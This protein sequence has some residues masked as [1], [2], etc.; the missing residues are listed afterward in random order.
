MVPD[1]ESAR[2]AFDDE[3]PVAATVRPLR[4]VALVGIDGSGK[5]TQAHELAH[6]LAARGLPAS[7]RRNAGGR[8]WF[9]RLATALGRRD[10]EHLLGRKAMLF[11]ESVLRW[12]A[13]LRTLLRRTVT[14]EIAI[15]DR[16][17]VCQ[18]ASIRAHAKTPRP[19]RLNRA[20]RRA[21]LA[22]RVFPRPD[23][24]FLLAVDPAVAHDRIERRGYDH[25]EMSYLRAATAA[26]EAL[27]EYGNFVVVDANG[28]PE[29][30]QQALLA[31]LR[32]WLPAPVP[33]P[34]PRVPAEPRRAGAVLLQARA[35]L[36][37]AVTLAAAASALTCQLV[38][39]F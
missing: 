27:P 36:L 28:T 18:Y 6:A 39:G 4:S 7:Y 31:H 2:P 35:L 37:T 15:M 26:Y 14:R 34:A 20:E 1:L 29:Q 22:Y 13:I 8:R 33:V 23:V 5:T 21:R 10:G 16:Y 3:H 9:G 32:A 30:V 17:A 24:T 38:E 11:V 19:Q 12:L 25:E